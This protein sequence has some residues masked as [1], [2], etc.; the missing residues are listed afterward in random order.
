MVT[1]DSYFIKI[2]NDVSE[3][4]HCL[5]WKAG[6]VIV[7]DRQILS[8]GYNGPPSG[9]PHC[10]ENNHLYLLQTL[11]G[12]PTEEMISLYASEN[13]CPRRLYGYPSGRGLEYC[14]ASHAET[15]A[16]VQAAK[17]GICIEGSTLYCAFNMIPCREC[18]KLIVNSGIKEVVLTDGP[19]DYPQIGISGRNILESC[20][21][22]VRI[23]EKDN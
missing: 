21:I 5:S 3:K 8:T 16:I 1:W 19:N 7:N 22:K 15:N 18:S 13:I 6:V 23:M 9:Y 14:P 12:V 4:S 17:K 10:N 20:G 2:A 11:I